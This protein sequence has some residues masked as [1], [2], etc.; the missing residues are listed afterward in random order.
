MTACDIQHLGCTGEA[1]HELL[2]HDQ[3]RY[4]CAKRAEEWDYAI[5]HDAR[6]IKHRGVPYWNHTAL[7]ALE[8]A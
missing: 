7:R 5:R 8:H 4:L 2:F 1:T 6:C 3:I